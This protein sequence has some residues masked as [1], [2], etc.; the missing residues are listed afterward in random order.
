LT[1]N[2]KR[3]GAM[4]RRWL[5]EQ[6]R[7]IERDIARLHDELT[8]GPRSRETR[9]QFMRRLADDLLAVLRLHT[10][11]VPKRGRSPQARLSAP[12]RPRG[13][14]KQS[15]VT[16]DEILTL[17]EDWK[18]T[19]TPPGQRAMS[20]RRALAELLYDGARERPTIRR[21]I[22]RQLQWFLQEADSNA[23][24]THAL[25]KAVAS[26]KETRFGS[27]VKRL[28]RA[29]QNRRRRPRTKPQ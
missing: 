16:D 28:D 17:V 1:F 22:D 26:V 23:A 5:A 29:R 14:P 15:D 4:Q 11:V 18:R 3:F 19:H 12:P 27:W 6:T 20:D 25:G 7:R 10:S 24:V 21:Q 13:R 2:A 8:R 9:E